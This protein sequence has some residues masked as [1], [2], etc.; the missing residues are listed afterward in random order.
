MEDRVMGKKDDAEQAELKALREAFQGLKGREPKSDRELQ[1]W[2]ASPE[3]QAATAFSST[4]ASRW[5]DV[6]RS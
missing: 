5:G 2:L 1:E 3:G 4:S 6:G